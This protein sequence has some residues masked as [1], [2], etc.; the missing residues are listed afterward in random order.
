MYRFLCTAANVNES[1]TST[2]YWIDA[3]CIDQSNIMERNHQVAQM[4]TTYSQAQGVSI[5][6]GTDIST[7]RLLKIALEAWTLMRQ[8]ATFAKFQA[9]GKNKNICNHEVATDW[10]AFLTHAYWTR[11]WTTQEV[12]LAREVYIQ[13]DTIAVRAEQLRTICYLQD[14]FTDK[15]PTTRLFGDNAALGTRSL[16]YLEEMYSPR[17]RE[18]RTVVPPINDHQG[19]NGELSRDQIHSVTLLPLDGPRVPVDYAMHDC[20][21]LYRLMKGLRTSIMCICSVCIPTATLEHF[22]KAGEKGSDALRFMLTLEAR[23]SGRFSF[24]AR[25]P[26]QRLFTSLFT[27]PL[28]SFNRCSD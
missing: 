14:M 3:L 2:W 28:V 27:E 12:L 19:R 21:I 7:T 8:S 11:A 25:T 15:F 24:E 17:R 10:A 4:G 26:T 5:W 22:Q 6:M 16:R 23:Q 1:S 13:T 9:A 18:E 20:E